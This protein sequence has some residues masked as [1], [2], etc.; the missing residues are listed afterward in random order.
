MEQTLARSIKDKINYKRNEKERVE[1]NFIATF[2]FI[3]A[4]L[5]FGLLFYVFDPIITYLDATF[6]TTGPYAMVM[7]WLWGVLAAINLFGSGIRLIM[8]M[9]SQRGV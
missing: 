1:I 7:F 5:I 3:T 4:I 8:L 9:Q 2:H 6:P